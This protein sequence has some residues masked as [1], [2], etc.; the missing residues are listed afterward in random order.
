M[1]FKDYMR[2]HKALETL[3]IPFGLLMEAFGTPQEAIQAANEYAQW[4]SSRK[5]QGMAGCGDVP[6]Q[7]PI[8]LGLL[9]LSQASGTQL[10]N[11]QDLEGIKKAY[12]KAAMKF[13]PDRNAGD[14]V[15]EARFKLSDAIF[16]WFN[17]GCWQ[18]YMAQ[19]A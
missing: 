14:K 1:K 19:P 5:S 10:T 7:D 13:H 11:P 2:L 15:A 17:E 8:G 16:H 9:I 3:N 12:R 18:K 6:D 4:F